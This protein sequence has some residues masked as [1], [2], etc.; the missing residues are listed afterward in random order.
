MSISAS[1]EAFDS[2]TSDVVDLKALQA[3]TDLAAPIAELDRD[4][5]G[6]APVKQRIREI[7]AFLLV[8]RARQEVGLI[9]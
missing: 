3:E 6:L 8:A 2:A 1:P 4:L 9:S 7:A 5:V